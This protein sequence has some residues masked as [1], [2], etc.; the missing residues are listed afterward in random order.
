MWRFFSFAQTQPQL[1][2]CAKSQQKYS[3]EKKRATVSVNIN[4][5]GSLWV[6]I[7]LLWLNW[8]YVCQNEI[9]FWTYLLE[10]K[11]F[12]LKAS[13]YS[14]KKNWE[15]PF[16]IESSFRNWFP[17]LMSSVKDVNCVPHECTPFTTE[18]YPTCTPFRNQCT[19]FGTWTPGSP[20]LGYYS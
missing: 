1:I 8:I 11:D 9:L 12:N 3:F 16:Q 5:E 2:K 7:V 19:P 13:L 20:D 18:L 6:S 17:S 4:R 15:C 10:N 14:K